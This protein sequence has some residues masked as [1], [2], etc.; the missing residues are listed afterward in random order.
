[1]I[2]PTVILPSVQLSN[3]GTAVEPSEEMN[4]MSINLTTPQ[5]AINNPSRDKPTFLSCTLSLPTNVLPF[6]PHGS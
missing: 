1:M 3:P 6:R 5:P 4:Q 2:L